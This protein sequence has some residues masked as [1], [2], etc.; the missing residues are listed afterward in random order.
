[1]KYTLYGMAGIT[2]CSLLLSIT[3]LKGNDK[4]YKGQFNQ[5]KYLN[6]NYFHDKRAVFFLISVP[7]MTY[8]AV[9]PGSMKKNEDVEGFVLSQEKDVQQNS[10]IKKGKDDE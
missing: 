4:R 3:P 9:T 2:F 6:E 8:L 1:M 5:D 10:L 7:M